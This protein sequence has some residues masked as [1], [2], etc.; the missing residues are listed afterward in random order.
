MQIIYYAKTERL[1]PSIV[2]HAIALLYC[3]IVLLIVWSGHILQPHSADDFEIAHKH[4]NI[5]SVHVI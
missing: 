1:K 3:K 2:K 5:L 4:T